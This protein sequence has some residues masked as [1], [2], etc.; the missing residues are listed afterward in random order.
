[1][2]LPPNSSFGPYTILAPL[3]AGGMG[4]VYR[5]RDAKLGR[6]LAIK[7][8]PPE[9]A[10]DRERLARFEQ[11]ARAASALN[12]PNIITIFEVGEAAGTPYIAMEVV[13]GRSLRDL[14]DEGKL[15]LRKAI[16]IAAQIAD[17]LAAAHERGVVH[18]DLKP[19]NVMVTKSGHVKLLDFGLAKLTAVEQTE[20]TMRMAGQTHPGA[21]MGTVGYMSPEQASGRA[22]DFRSD[23][24][25]LGAILYEML[26]GRRAF[27]KATS[28]ETLTAILRD[29]PEPLAPADVPPVLR[30]I[31]ERLLA[32]TADERY[33]STRD[34]ARDLQRVRDSLSDPTL[35]SGASAVAPPSHRRR[36]FALIAAVVALG[37]VGVAAWAA[38]KRFTRSETPVFHRITFR[39]GYITSARFGPDGKTIVYGAGW[40]G[41][42]VSIYT[43][44]EENSESLGLPLP[45]ADVLSVTKDGRMAI[46]LGRRYTEWFVS[47]GELAEAPLSGGAAPRELVDN[48]QDADFF[49]DGRT[50]AVARNGNA[51]TILEFPPGT[52]RYTSA[53]WISHVR[54]APD[55]Q[56]V[57]FIDH[58]LRGDDRGTLTVIDRGGKR[59]ALTPMFA[60]A[61][62][63]AWRP[64][65]REIWFGAAETGFSCAIRAVTLDGKVRL[66]LSGPSRLIVHD[67]SPTGRVLL[68][69]EEPQVGAIAAIGGAERDL[70]WLDCSFA[71]DIAPDGSK[72]LISEQGEGAKAPSAVY[73]R[74]SDGSAA[75]RVADGFGC[76]F[77]PD[78]KTVLVQTVDDPPHLLLVPL[79]AGTT[80]DLT[81]PNMGQYLWPQWFPDGKRIVYSA[82]RPNGAPRLYV[83]NVDGGAPAPVSPDGVG[84]GLTPKPVSPDGSWIAATGGNGKL[85]LWPVAGGAPHVIPNVMPN[86]NALRF[87]ADGKA[88]FTYVAGERPAKLYRLDVTTGAHSV[89]KEIHPHDDA[90]VITVIPTVALPDGKTYGYTYLRMS[91]GLFVVDGL[92]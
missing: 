70:S 2:T 27:Q 9:F 79:G 58:P 77:S 62:G 64:D 60:S 20:E 91:G 45:P 90:G 26:T 84:G 3:G 51:Q 43:A 56:H 76:A 75:F 59:K 19:E 85:A 49:P 72:V 5:A 73:V 68:A 10:A 48:V 28:V 22:A 82:V 33:D 24:F 65:G 34:L 66:V 11:E 92:K 29:E 32:K 38:A 63:V 39:R 46:S 88:L 4:A 25:S 61:Q 23:Q 55:G 30:W 67:I 54:V 87:S 17:G 83:Q 31:V 6:D 35:T 44:R 41:N 40:E 7:V 78:A 12:H 15:P 37:L 52:A 50:L 57:A 18:R 80:R 8:L 53:G 14:L 89:I 36:A 86:E 13:E 47:N 1:M 81:T 74:S 21:V 16:G 71:S 69:S 42:P